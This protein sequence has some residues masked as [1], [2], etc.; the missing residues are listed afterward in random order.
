MGEKLD[1]AKSYLFEN[2]LDV[3][4]D[5]GKE[6]VKEVITEA[7]TN[8]VVEMGA[9]ALVEIGGS[10]IPGI[11]GAISSYRNAKRFKNVEITLEKLRLDHSELKRKFNEQTE[12]NKQILDDIFDMVLE[13]VSGFQQSEKIDYILHGYSKMLDLDNPSFDTA[14]LFFDVLDR[15]TLLD[16][17]VLQISYDSV[18]VYFDADGSHKTYQDIMEKFDI[19][20]SQYVS[21][22]ENLYRMGLLE[23]EYDNKV[24]RDLSDMATAV[25]ELRDVTESM[26]IFISGKKKSARL[27]SLSSKSK[28]KLKAKERLKISKFGRQFIDFFLQAEE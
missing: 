1:A 9:N 17:A 7:V 2:V 5:Y 10:M 18:N 15:L 12:E 25:N 23:D 4:V 13:K 3:A 14:Y 22:R 19:D 28:V 8:Q 16:I 20:Y 6:N 27:K 26:L 11:G 21:I 24:G